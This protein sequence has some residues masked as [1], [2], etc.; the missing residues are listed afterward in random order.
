[1]KSYL[2]I[3]CCWLMLAQSQAQNFA[4]VGAKWH[5]GFNERNNENY[6]VLEALKD[7]VISTDTFSAIGGNGNTY[8]IKQENEKVYY[9]LNAK[10]CLLFDTEKQIGDTFSVDVYFK[11]SNKDTSIIS[12][13]VIDTVFYQYNTL[14]VNDSVRVY[15]LQHIN[16]LLGS[17]FN[18]GY[19]TERFIKTFDFSRHLIS[20]FNMPAQGEVEFN[21]RCYSTP[22]YNFKDKNLGDR[23]CDYIYSALNEYGFQSANIY[24]NPVSD[25]LNINNLRNNAEQLCIINNIGQLMLQQKI[26]NQNQSLI[27]V[28]DFTQ[29][30]YYITIN[31]NTGKIIHKV[32]F[33]KL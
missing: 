31:D 4:P 32:K 19:Y 1:M 10:K 13:I 17:D 18:P 15:K 30:L 9:L 27:M 3:I 23:P 24:P 21:F 5:Y 20:L 14:D 12:Q 11:L 2:L 16:E 7:T 33:T 28:K 8:Y 29:G 25:Y 26:T 6:I 22:N